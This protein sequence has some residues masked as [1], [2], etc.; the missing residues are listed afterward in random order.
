MEREILIKYDEI[1]GSYEDACKNLINTLSEVEVETEYSLKRI[2]ELLK[3]R[4]NQLKRNEIDEYK[5]KE[6]LK[7]IWEYKIRCNKNDAEDR[8]ANTLKLF[9]KDIYKDSFHFFLELIQNA[10]DASKNGDEHSLKI[11]LDKD[12]KIIFEYDE[13]GFNFSDLFAITSLG[14]SSKKA[15]LSDNASIGEKGIGFKSIFSVINEI[16]IKSKYFSFGILRGN[17]LS[18]ILEPSKVT[19]ETSEKTILTLS[20]NKE[21]R[22]KEFFDEIHTW[23]QSNVMCEEFNNPFLFLK[24]IRQVS[25]INMNEMNEEIKIKINKEKINENFIHATIE[26]EENIKEY[27][28]YTENMIFNKEAIKSRWNHLESELEEKSEDFIIN[29]PSQIAFPLINEKCDKGQIYSYLPTNIEMD[30]PVFINLDVH[31]TASR[32]NIKAE[33]FE[34]DSLWNKQV[35]ENL[36]NFLLNAYLAVIGTH[37]DDN[38]KENSSLKKLREEFY[39]YIPTKIHKNIYAEQIFNKINDFRDKLKEEAI[40]LSNKDIFIKPESIYSIKGNDE[41]LKILYKFIGEPNREIYDNMRFPKNEHWNE[42]VYNI[43]NSCNKYTVYDFVKAQQGIKKYFDEQGDKNVLESIIKMLKNDI[44][45]IKGD[46]DNDITIIPIESNEKVDGFDLISN[47]STE[48]VIFL[49]YKNEE[50]SKKQ[51]IEDTK[52]SIYIYEGENEIKGLKELVKKIYGITEYNLNDYFNGKKDELLNESINEKAIS[53]FI[54]ETFRFFE[55]NNNCFDNIKDLSEIKKFL[56]QYTF[57]EEDWLKYEGNEVN[58]EY[59]EAMLSVNRLKIWTIPVEYE[60]KDE[61]IKY[62]MFLGIKHQIEFNNG[63]LDYIS[64]QIIEEKTYNPIVVDKYTREINIECNLQKY[65]LDTINDN[66]NNISK[67]NLIKY[68]KKLKL[69]N[70]EENKYKYGE[71]EIIIIEDSKIGELNNKISEFKNSNKETYSLDESNLCI[72][73]D[74]SFNEIWKKLSDENTDLVLTEF[75]VKKIIVS[76]YSEGENAL[77]DLRMNNLLNEVFKCKY[78]WT[79]EYSFK[80]KDF[81]KFY[82]SFD[83]SENLGD[84]LSKG[85]IVDLTELKTAKEYFEND[86]EDFISKILSHKNNQELTESL[87]SFV[88]VEDDLMEKAYIK[89]NGKNEKENVY[90]LKKREGKDSLILRSIFEINK[91]KLEVHEIKEIQDYFEELEELIKSPLESI[92]EGHDKYCKG[93]FFDFHK[94]NIERAKD[95]LKSIWDKDILQQLCAPFELDDGTKMEGYG[96]TCP[97]CGEKS[98]AALSGMNFNRFKKNTLVPLYIVSCANCNIMLKYAKYIEI[99]DFDKIMEDFEN[100][101]CVDNDH[102]KNHSN[103]M[104]VKLKVKTWNNAVKNLDMKM[105]Y[106]NMVLYHKLT[107]DKN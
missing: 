87:S 80:L 91:I 23:M 60:N 90:L 19:L 72:V 29:R 27:I 14:N 18:S 74:K 85:Y 33:D 97:I 66:I 82:K 20:L 78:V 49:H 69:F 73:S 42:L 58:K 37:Y 47:K 96:Y 99:L 12:Y 88:I 1:N 92:Y 101:Y 45:N 94:N 55:D 65:F 105:S 26:K 84:L 50:N 3:E 86:I 52:N 40:I 51:E 56:S 54:K 100:C 2:L 75:N 70:I 89:L 41:D 95:I 7:A 81:L 21:L 8:V 30:F 57:S 5:K 43:N 93:V 13:R 106:L 11:I 76:F 104:T 67:D 64:S 79:K 103:M 107:S 39:C 6:L 35:N 10:D 38:L 36:L 22:T 24:N 59:I 68:C 28:I 62:L 16:D 34:E 9:T 102:I 83:E 63:E 25:Y 4:D 15:K 53:D 46:R 77:K 31:L 61:Y 17:K 98:S 71:K 32:G 44:S 48:K